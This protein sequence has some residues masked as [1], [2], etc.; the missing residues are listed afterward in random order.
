M[1]PAYAYP[2]AEHAPA[3]S[4]TVMF[5]LGPDT[6]WPTARTGGTPGAGAAS[7]KQPSGDPEHVARTAA[8]L[9]SKTSI[10]YA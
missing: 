10:R 1:S 7:K 5:A 8:A 9:E 2:C 4:A 3:H 6:R